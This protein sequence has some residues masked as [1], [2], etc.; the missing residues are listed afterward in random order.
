VQIK[1]I[2]FCAIG[3]ID[4]FP[5]INVNKFI[6]H[7]NSQLTFR[8]K[9]VMVENVRKAYRYIGHVSRYEGENCE[10]VLRS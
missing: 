4:E 3:S 7:R 6:I 10:A 9:L 5:K 8:S 2:D 1:K